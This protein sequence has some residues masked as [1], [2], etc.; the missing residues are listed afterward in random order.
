MGGGT[1]TCTLCGSAVPIRAGQ[2]A[3]QLPLP[4][5]LGAPPAKNA[6]S[7]PPVWV[8]IMGVLGVAVLLCCGLPVG[9]YFWLTSTPSASAQARTPFPVAS[10]PVPSFPD[11]GPAIPMGNGVA[12]YEIRLGEGNFPRVPG[13]GGKLWLYLPPGQHG[14][15]SL[16]CVLVAPAGSTMLCGNT[17]GELS[18][19]YH[20]EHLPYAEAG[21]AVVGYELDG[22]LADFEEEDDTEL[23]RAYLAFRAAQAGLVNARNALEFVLAK[24]PEVNRNRVFAAGHSSAGSLA[25]LFAEHEPRLRAAVAYAPVTDLETWLEPPAIRIQSLIM[26]DLA[27]FV[28]RSSP[29]TH[30]ANLKCPLLLFHALDDTNV[31]V[32]ESQ[33]CAA[34]LKALGKDVTLITV[35]SGDHYEAMIEE[36]IPLAIDWLKKF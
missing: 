23:R 2:A 11:R 17:L 3:G 21:F 25:M 27:D 13:Q 16:P 36:G 8:W 1:I 24:V 5:P 9:F 19:D 22:P 35:P 4:Q 34:R 12:L 15:G 6:S 18:D 14:P 26:P 31:P 32:E 29:K 10:V 7:G 33:T 20:D 30:E 28:V